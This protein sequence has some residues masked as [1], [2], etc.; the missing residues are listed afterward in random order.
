MV[1]STISIQQLDRIR[2]IKLNRPQAL[3][4]IDQTMRLELKQA[5][6]T[7]ADSA[8]VIVL[9]AEGRVFSSGTD[10]KEQA[11]G[12]VPS[13]ERLLTEEYLPMLD[14]ILQTPLPV[15]GAVSGDVVGIGI[16][17]VLNCDALVMAD[18]AALKL[19]F[20]KIGLIPDGGITWHLNRY[21][22]HQTVFRWLCEGTAI[23]SQ[24]CFDAGMV[25]EV[26][27]VDRVLDTAIERAE[28]LASLSPEMVRS[29]KRVLREGAGMGYSEAVALEARLQSDCTASPAFR[30]AHEKFIQRT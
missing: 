2:I 6:E 10:L 3:N 5:F 15:I 20:S 7:A 26:V 14:A 29:I 17:L 21:F 8:D 12:E 11:A 4:A 9:C 22:P 13:T 27:A 16:A 19:A 25:N 28:Q 1:P 30:A 24:Q 23:S 18:D